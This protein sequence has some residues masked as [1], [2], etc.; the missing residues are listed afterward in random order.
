MWRGPPMLKLHINAL[1]AARFY[2]LAIFC[3]SRWA[4]GHFRRVVHPTQHRRRVWVDAG[5]KGGAS[6]GVGARTRVRN[7]GLRRRPSSLCPRCCWCCCVG[8]QEWHPQLTDVGVW[9]SRITSAAAN[10]RLLSYW[11]RDAILPC[12]QLWRPFWL[13]R[14]QHFET[15]IFVPL[16]WHSHSIAN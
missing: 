9:R 5:W 10:L 4:D 1:N 16:M 15:I 3:Q 7:K 14:V 12:N 11:S 2:I 6:E 13:A 8:V